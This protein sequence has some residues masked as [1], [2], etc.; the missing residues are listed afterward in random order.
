[1]MTKQEQMYQLIELQQASGQTV[2]A[3]CEQEHI[4]LHTFHYWSRKKRQAQ[5]SAFIPLDITS[6]DS[7]RN[8]VE[9]IYPNQVKLRL[10][11]FDLKQIEQLIRLSSCSA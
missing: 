9:L 7:G 2:K 5:T 3:F 6:R 10:K 4:K 11:H 1:M 8:Q